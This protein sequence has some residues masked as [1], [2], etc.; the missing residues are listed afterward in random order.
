MASQVVDTDGH[1]FERDE[2]IFDYLEP[3]YRGRKEL[4]AYPF[5][6]PP[7]GFHRMARRIVDKRPFVIAPDDPKTW[8]K[9]LDREG[10]DRTVIYPTAGLGVGFIQDAEW[11][12]VACRAYNNMMADRYIK[13]DSRLG[14][15][16]L[17][18]IQDIKESAKELHRAV[19]DLKMHGGIL[20]PAGFDKPLGDT[21]FDPLY[22]EAQS[23]GCPL[24]IHGA[25]SRGLGLDF[26]RTLIEVRTLSHPFLQMIHLTSIVLEGVLERFP[27]LKIASLEAGCQW[28]PFLMDRLDMEYGNRSPQAPLLKMKPSEYMSGGQIYY[29]AE[30]WE[31][32]LPDVIERVGEDQILYATDYPHEPD[33]ASAIR[34]FE[35]RKDLSASAKRKI[36][37]DNG[38]RFYKMGT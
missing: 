17:L 32:M 8:A 33:L 37:S 31:K 25:P 20:A 23:L 35:A 2:I 34:K 7:D 21:Y 15:V 27:K 28:I 16:A 24:A 3:P 12:V 36:L 26:F 11:A 1:I 18:P 38:T 5:F 29:H 10:I 22:S 9:V 6:P 13:F 4:F 14:A 19:K 30:L